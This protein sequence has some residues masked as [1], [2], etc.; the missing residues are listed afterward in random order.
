MRIMSL[1][2]MTCLTS[3]ATS[4]LA[5]TNG[6]AFAAAPRTNVISYRDVG[7]EVVITGL[8]GQ[9]IGT[10]VTITGSNKHSK[11][12]LFQVHEVNGG[13]FI[14]KISVD[15]F[16]KWPDGLE[17]TLEGY[18]HGEIRLESVWDGSRT[19]GDPAIGKQHIWT[20]FH[21][22]RIMKPAGLDPAATNSLNWSYVTGRRDVEE[23]KAMVE[24]ATGMTQ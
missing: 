21:V 12:V 15:G 24:K 9:P 19:F 3:M 13:K 14:T 17:A 7:K 4:L 22:L 1:L 10:T 8:L 23:I 16:D 18:E 11:T 5:E 20:R 6:T 2:A